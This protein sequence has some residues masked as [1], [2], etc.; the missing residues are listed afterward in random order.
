MN[1]LFRID[2]NSIRQGEIES[3]GVVAIPGLH[4]LTPEKPEESK[5]QKAPKSEKCDPADI[6][7]NE[8]VALQ[9]Q[10]EEAKKSAAQILEDA[11]NRAIE[12]TKQSEQAGYDEGIR[13][14]QQELKKEIEQ[15]RREVNALKDKLALAKQNMFEQLESGIIDLS[16]CI[17]EKIVKETIDRNDEVFLNIVHDVLSIVKEQSNIILKVSKR[18]YDRFFAKD[19]DEFTALLKSSGIQIKQDFS[20]E[21]GECTIETDLGTVCSGVRLQLE[22][23]ANTFYEADEE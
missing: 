20:I 8:L 5:I 11:E 23:I 2:R 9:E 16:I 21:S 18:E 17:A 19:D 14:A 12:I 10:I 4:E 13:Q 7:K 22:Q 6:K 1:S 3:A 15:E